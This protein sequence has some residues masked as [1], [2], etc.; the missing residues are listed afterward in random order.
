MCADDLL[1]RG[2]G[3]TE[4]NDREVFVPLPLHDDPRLAVEDLTGS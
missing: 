1:G 4:A 3:G 2:Q